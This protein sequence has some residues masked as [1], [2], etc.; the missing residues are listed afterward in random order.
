M[1][2]FL[3]LS[4]PFSPSVS[5]SLPSLHDY[6]N[7][8]SISSSISLFFSFFPSYL[9]LYITSVTDISYTTASSLSTISGTVTCKILSLSLSLPFYLSFSLSVFEIKQSSFPS[10]RQLFFYF[11]FYFFIYFL[12]SYHSYLITLHISSMTNI[13]FSTT[14]LKIINIKNNSNMNLPTETQCNIT[15]E[16]YDRKK[17]TC[18]LLPAA[19]P[20][21][22]SGSL[23]Q[24]LRTGGGGE[25][26]ERTGGQVVGG[27]G[28]VN[29]RHSSSAS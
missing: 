6:N 7:Y 18:P 24:V 16:F 17:H 8:Y 22:T 5:L 4:L 9:V 21:Q 15:L 23:G 20:S 29:P 27:C 2:F 13:F 28:P 1:I 11:F 12:L 26:G 19:N 10:K 3:F 25:G 14:A